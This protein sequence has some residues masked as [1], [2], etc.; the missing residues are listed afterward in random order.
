MVPGKVAGGTGGMAW[1]LLQEEL[2]RRR[3]KFGNTGTPVSQP[4]YWLGRPGSCC[5]GQG[6]LGAQDA[7]SVGNR[8][9]AG[10]GTPLQLVVNWTQCIRT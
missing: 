9:F 2:M 1:E 5:C 7:D 8:L 4:A 3:D 10:R 6:A